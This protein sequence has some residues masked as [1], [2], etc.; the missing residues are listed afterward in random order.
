MK[1]GLRSIFVKLAVCTLAVTPPLPARAQQAPTTWNDF[2][3]GPSSGQVIA[4]GVGIAVAGTA[5]GIGTYYAFHHNHNLTG[6]AA[7]TPDGLRLQKDGDGQTYS[8]VGEI[9]AIRPGDRVRLSGKKEKADAT[10]PR[11]FL[12]E[13]V[14]K[15]FGSCKVQTATP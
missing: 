6:C 7:V 13:K 11:L 12:V 2:Q 4:I 15:D 10:G 3:I 14:K 5:I 9:A 8:L 1:I